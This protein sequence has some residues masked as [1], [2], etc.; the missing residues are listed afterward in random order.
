MHPAI[1]ITNPWFSYQ[2]KMENSILPLG[3][4]KAQRLYLHAIRLQTI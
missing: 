1:V 2:K 3:T 4:K